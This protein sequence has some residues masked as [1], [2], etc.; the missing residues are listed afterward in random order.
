[1]KK[2]YNRSYFFDQG[3][4]FEC[5]RCGACCIGDPGIVYV[6]ID[7]VTRIAEYLSDEIFSV[8]DKYLFPLRAGYRIREHSDGRCYFYDNGCTIYPVRPHQCKTYPF[9]FENLRSSKKWKRVLRECPGI[10]CGPL[11][12]KEKILEIVQST[13][14]A[15]VESYLKDN[16]K[17]CCSIDTNIKSE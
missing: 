4:H 14:D 11:Y 10:G 13:M 12:P 5:Q 9:W 6:G 16:S 17:I 1:M 2:L 8:A 3:I 15:V 7:E